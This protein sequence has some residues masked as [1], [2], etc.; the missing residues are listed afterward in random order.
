MKY[1]PLKSNKYKSI[2]N[3]ATV[4]QKYFKDAVISL[5]QDEEICYHIV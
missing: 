4:Y 5:I 3:I 2:T 1:S